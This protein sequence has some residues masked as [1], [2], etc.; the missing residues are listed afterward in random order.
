MATLSAVSSHQWLAIQLLEREEVAKPRLKPWNHFAK[1]RRAPTK[2]GLP[3]WNLKNSGSSFVLFPA[4]D[5]IT[6][7]LM[8]QHC[9]CERK[10]GRRRVHSN[11]IWFCF[12]ASISNRCRL[13]FDH[14]SVGDSFLEI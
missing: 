10:T 12:G 11:G 6:A 14:N 3:Y 7:G 5:S 1:L 8:I 9:S 4:K 13:N 2:A